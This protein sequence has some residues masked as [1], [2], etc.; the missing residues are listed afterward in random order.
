MP[1]RN[2]LVLLL[3]TLAVTALSCPPATFAQGTSH[4]VR[5]QPVVTERGVTYQ[6][7]NGCREVV[8]VSID[9]LE[10]T[11]EW[12]S[13]IDREYEWQRACQVELGSGETVIAGCAIPETKRV[14]ATRS[15]FIFMQE[16][17]LQ[18][19]GPVLRATWSEVEAS[20]AKLAADR[21][22]RVAAN[23]KQMLAEGVYTRASADGYDQL[24]AATSLSA[25]NL[26]AQFVGLPSLTDEASRQYRDLLRTCIWKIVRAEVEQKRTSGR[27][28]TMV[29]LDRVGALG[30]EFEECAKVFRFRQVR[31]SPTG[32]EFTI[33][34]MFPTLIATGY[35]FGDDLKLR[36]ADGAPPPPGKGQV[37]IGNWTRPDGTIVLSAPPPAKE[38]AAPRAVA[39][40]PVS[41]LGLEGSAVIAVLSLA[42][43]EHQ[44]RQKRGQ[45]G[46]MTDLRNAGVLPYTGFSDPP[47]FGQLRGYRLSIMPSAQ[48][49]RIEAVATG[50]EAAARSFAI[51]QA[52]PLRELDS[53]VAIERG[54][55]VDLMNASVRFWLQ[56]VAR[57]QQEYHVAHG[58]Y[59]KHR[60]FVQRIH[61]YPRV[62][63]IDWN[64]N[65]GGFQYVAVPVEANTG[66]KSYIVDH[67]GRVR[68]K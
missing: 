42:R 45:F 63:K 12:A 7:T 56:E 13:E 28:A 44:Y 2:R 31:V 57:L 30:S 64:L 16:A 47:A 6:V 27:Y 40:D 41:R 10:L 33:E 26:A 37:M 51:E 46:T 21:T 32:F 22:R 50:L 49:F 24:E 39:D 4:C 38:V 18:I 1:C 17:D 25:S 59:A 54:E 9:V 8:R 20:W 15:T 3:V 34:P 11:D 62:Y 43:A 53:K 58:S 68:E 29:E 61:E 60:A 23:R 66:L 52:G 48:G 55:V 19:R 5:V 14:R 65:N 35:R 67:T 36:F